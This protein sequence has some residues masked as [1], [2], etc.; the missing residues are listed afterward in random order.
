V[1]NGI[2]ILKETKKSCFLFRMVLMNIFDVCDL[3]DNGTLCREEF[4]IYNVRTGD[5]QVTDEEWRVVQGEEG[6]KFLLCTILNN[7]SVLM[8]CKNACIVANSSA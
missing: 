7:A 4:N 2:I 5:E 3:D 8:L 1:Q 6:L